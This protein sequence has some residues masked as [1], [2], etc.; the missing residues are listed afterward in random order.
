MEENNKIIKENKFG[1]LEV[2]VLL[3]LTCFISVMSGMFLGHKVTQKAF[4]KN[5]IPEELN[6]LISNYNYIVDN[7]YGDVDKDAVVKGAIKGM[8]ESLGDKYT[9]FLDESS[10]NNFNIQLKGSFTGVGVEIISAEKGITV[11]SVFED[12]PAS[13]ADIK[14]GDVILKIDDIDLTGK[15]SNELIN[16]IKEKQG[17]FKL[18]VKR[19]EEE[20]TKVLKKDLIVIKS[21]FGKTYEE[22]D[23]KIGYLEVTLFASNTYEQFKQELEKLENEKVD[24][25][26]I[27]VRWNSGGHLSSVEKMISLFLDTS[28]IIYQTESKDGV[29]K[30]YSSGTV[31]KKYPIVLL[32][33]GESASAS[34]LLMGALRDE[35][36]A[37]IVGTKSFGKGTVQELNTLSSADQYKITTKKWLT[38]KGESI[39]KV[40]LVPDVEVEQEPEYYESFDETK[41]AQLRKA[42]K[43]FSSF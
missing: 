10:N 15:T 34:E 35:L 33:N 9:S 20:L 3:C 32:S 11:L 39:D 38:P 37:K 14:V 4:D 31:T 36:G 12:S 2:T 22:N 40:G 42:L 8:V 27:D 6:E 7:F 26:I 5:K 21:V 30:T 17:E 1:S 18:V 19:D 28:H 25:L 29:E 23:K 41:D 24:G 43:L 16:V 13:K